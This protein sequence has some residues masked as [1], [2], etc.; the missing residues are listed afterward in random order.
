MVYPSSPF[1][2]LTRD[3]QASCY[4]A[5]TR[6]R[7]HAG[8]SVVSI[9]SGPYPEHGVGWEAGYKAS[10]FG[11]R[12]IVGAMDYLPTSAQLSG[13]SMDIP[14]ATPDAILVWGRSDD[15]R[16]TGLIDSLILQYP[17]NSIETIIDPTLGEV[18]VV[19][20]ISR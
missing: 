10:F 5:G 8:S 7:A 20:F 15:T 17:H 11:R 3:F 13:L 1:R 18:G 14:K 9:G 2:L 4:D 12:K 16:Y 19:L 6:L